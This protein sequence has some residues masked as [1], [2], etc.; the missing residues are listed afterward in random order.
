MANPNEA[1]K[2]ILKQSQSMMANSFNMEE[3]LRDPTNLLTGSCTVSNGQNEAIDLSI[4]ERNIS[5]ESADTGSLCSS[6]QVEEI[7][8]SDDEDIAELD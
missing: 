5:R 4:N 2:R 6:L 3:L 1:H 7:V 8:D